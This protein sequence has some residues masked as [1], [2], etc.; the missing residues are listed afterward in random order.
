[1]GGAL[2]LTDLE[3]DSTQLLSYKER[4][5]MMLESL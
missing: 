5:T 4:T 2:Q 1:L 3:A